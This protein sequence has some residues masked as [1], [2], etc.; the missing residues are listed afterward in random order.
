LRSRLLRISPETRFIIA[1]AFAPGNPSATP[2]IPSGV[3]RAFAFPASFA[4]AVRSEGSAVDFVS[5]ATSVV[6]GKE[7]VDYS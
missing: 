4:G 3:P 7:R 2:V 6:P 1:P 5:D